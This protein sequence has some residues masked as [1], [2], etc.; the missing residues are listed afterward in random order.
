[1]TAKLIENVYFI[2]LYIMYMY[3]KAFIPSRAVE[4]EESPAKQIQKVVL[5]MILEICIL[6]V[7]LAKKFFKEI[8]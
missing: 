6:T 5:D 8:I 2:Y 1:M 4:T 3:V 7:Y